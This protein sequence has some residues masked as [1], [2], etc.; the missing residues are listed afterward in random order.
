MVCKS[1]VRY[2]PR[3]LAS[4]EEK[5]GCAGSTGTSPAGKGHA[6]QCVYPVVAP[7]SLDWRGAYR[8]A[9]GSM[10]MA[11]GG[12]NASACGQV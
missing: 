2:S 10:Q 5:K 7:V 11:G 8:Q 12:K 1:P 4:R 9:A 6:A 3:E